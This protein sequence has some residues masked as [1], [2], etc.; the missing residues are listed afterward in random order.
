MFSST[1]SSRPGVGLG[2]EQREVVLAEHARAHEPEQ[3]AELAGRDPAIGERHRR[4]GEAAAGR[5]DLV[6][7]VRLELADERREGRRCW[8]GPSRPGRRPPDALDDARAASVPSASRQAPARSAAIAARVGRFGGRAARP[9]SA[10]PGAAAQP[11]DG[12]PLDRRPVDEARARADRSA[13]RPA[14]V[15]AAPERRPD[16]EPG[17]PDAGR[18]ATAAAVRRPSGSSR[19]HR[20]GRPARRPGRP[21]RTGARR[22]ARKRLD[23]AGRQL[24]VGR[25]RPASR[26]G[27]RGRR[28]PAS[29]AVPR[30]VPGASRP[31]TDSSSASADAV[32]VAESTIATRSP[33]TA[34]IS[35]RSSG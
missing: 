6:E 33:T 9:R 25:P 4:L 26:P 8:R 13:C 34:A 27:A 17:L 32:A 22:R 10:C 31:L 21:P 1:N 3:E 23:V 30:V 35:G 7:Q 20:R 12:D 28:G 5:H 24:E 16:Q 11:A 15:A 2:R 18:R 19:R 14:T 29:A